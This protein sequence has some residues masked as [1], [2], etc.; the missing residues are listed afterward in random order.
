MDVAVDYVAHGMALVP[1][2]I[3]LKRP[4]SEGWNQQGN[5]ILGVQQANTLSGNVGLAHA[6]STPAPTMALDLDDMTR[7]VP[8]LA[9]RGVDVAELLE[10]DDAV[11]I[12]SG[13]P[14][15]AKLI[16][17][18]PIGHLPLESLTIK[19]KVG[20]RDKEKQITVLE[21]RCA[22]RDGLT[23]QDVLPPSIHPETGKPYCWG[24]KGDWRA[25]PVIP[26]ILLAV[27]RA[28]LAKGAPRVR[29]K[30]RLSLFKGIDDTPRQRAR[31]AD[32]LRYVSAD[33]SYEQYRDIV[34]AI[35]SFGWDD[36]EAIAEQWCR[37][38]PNRFEEL[39]FQAVVASYDEARAPT[40]GTIHHHAKAGGWHG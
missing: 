9:A 2:P 21:F 19:E 38:A 35:L 20:L 30:S 25:I 6:Y 32:M 12:V 13:R 40:I 24:G 28:E 37:T 36:V 18:M 10:A 22:T 31:V 27:W 33:A 34:W 7:A 1:I 14:G 16:Y 15:R 8:W 3:G 29:T 23:V 4:T 5:V 17:R 26:D 39:S 11:Q